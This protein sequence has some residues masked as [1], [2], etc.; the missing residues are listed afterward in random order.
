M[1]NVM[2][3]AN[4]P[5]AM[6]PPVAQHGAVGRVEGTPAHLNV[7]RL[8]GGDHHRS[9]PWPVRDLRRSALCLPDHAGENRT[10]RQHRAAALEGTPISGIQMTFRRQTLGEDYVV[11]RQFHM[12]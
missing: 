4:T 3:G 7:G 11:R 2:P 1:R 8:A 10:Q 9:M 12:V 6:V 5:E